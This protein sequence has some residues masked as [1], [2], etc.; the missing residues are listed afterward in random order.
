MN[1]WDIPPF[2]HFISKSSLFTTFIILSSFSFAHFPQF[3]Y[4]CT[5]CDHII[6]WLLYCTYTC[7]PVCVNNSWTKAAVGCWNVWITLDSVC[8]WRSSEMSL[9]THS[10]LYRVI[11]VDLCIYSRCRSWLPYH[12][13]VQCYP[14]DAQ[15]KICVTI[16]LL[17]HIHIHS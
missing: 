11:N 17:K 2:F 7:V 12:R 1:Y 13:L 3:L 5:S 16:P 15:I 9:Y 6:I 14:A 4:W 8:F 10:G